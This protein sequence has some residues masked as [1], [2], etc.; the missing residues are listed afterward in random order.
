MVTTAHIN[1][2]DKPVA[3][4]AQQRL[5]YQGQNR[6][7]IL[8]PNLCKRGLALSLLQVHLLGNHYAWKGEVVFCANN[9]PSETYDGMG[10]GR[11]IFQGGATMA[12][13]QK[14]S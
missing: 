8:Q 10:V 1:P 7:L 2:L 14:F 4:F 12:F 5:W 13:L 6:K 9:F 3:P 11:F